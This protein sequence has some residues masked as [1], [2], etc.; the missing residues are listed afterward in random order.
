MKRALEG[1][2][3]VE[4]LIVIMVMGI[5]LTLVLPGFTKTKERVYD[6]EAVVN[7]RLIQQAEKIYRME[8]GGYFPISDVGEAVNDI[9]EINNNL[10][11]DL[12]ER[13]WDYYILGWGNGLYYNAVASRVNPPNNYARQWE[14]VGSATTP[15]GDIICYNVSGSSGCP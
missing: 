14:S 12:N 7:I 5:L 9:N 15:N 3:L 2:T 4:L 10:R 13:I 6:K 1:F 11:L 8:N